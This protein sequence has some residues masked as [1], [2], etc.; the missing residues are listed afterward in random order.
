MSDHAEP[1]E[2][3]GPYE[4][5]VERESA[6]RMGMFVFLGSETLLFAGLFALYAGYRAEYPEAFAHAVAHNREWIGSVNTLILLCSS[7]L[8]AWAELAMRAA[9]PAVA[10][11]S[12]LAGGALGTCFLGLKGLEY[13]Q[14]WTQ[15]IRPGSWYVF[16]E[17]REPGASLFFSL[18]Y[19]LTALHALHVLAGLTALALVAY[20]VHRKPDA[21]H[22]AIRVELTALYW[23]LVDVVW[24]F[25]WPILYLIR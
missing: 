13:S 19:L 9:R 24:I 4:G 18:Y 14:H 21:S 12:L 16:A 11:L 3:F 20:S 22:N 23:H 10:K 5:R 6:Q 15:G 2:T 7:A 17:L 8:V 1:T 25:L